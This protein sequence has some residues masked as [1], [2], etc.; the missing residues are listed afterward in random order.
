MPSDIFFNL[1]LLFGLTVTVAVVVRLL[2]QPLLVAYLVSG[3]LAG[4]LFLNLVNSRDAFF[5]SFSQLGVVLLLF[6]VGLSLNTRHI[7][8]IGKTAFKTG[9]GQLVFTVLGALPILFWFG[10]EAQSALYLAI[11]VT[12]SSTIIVMKLLSDQKALETVYG[13]HTAGLLIVQDLFAMGMLIFL[14]N[15][16]SSWQ[17]WGMLLLKLLGLCA[18]LF[19]LSAR[20]LPPI[21]R[22]IAASGEFLFLSSVAWCFGVASIASIAGFSL[23]IGALLAGLSLGSSPYHYD[24]MSKMKPLR[25]FFIVLFFIILGSELQLSDIAAAWGP[26]LALSLFVIIGNPI[27]LY[28]LYRRQKFTR[29]NSFLASTAAAQVSEFGF[30]LLFAG[31]ELGHLSSNELPVFTLTALATIVVSSYVITYNDTIYRRMTPFFRLFGRDR[32]QNADE[33]G[34]T[35]GAWVAGYHRIG[36]KICEELKS[37]GISCAVVDYN[38]EA[39]EKARR[40][41]IPAFFGDVSDM[42]FLESLPIGSAH[43]IVSTI[44]EPEPQAALFRHAKKMSKKIRCIGTAGHTDTLG[45]LYEAGADYVMLPHLLGGR[46]MGELVTTQSLTAR[47]FAALRREQARELRAHHH[48]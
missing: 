26:S 43:L 7:G 24:I 44:P 12:F 2:G 31:R 29:R 19:I 35:Y 36:W 13:R 39:I 3:I 25:D 42:E 22:R 41:G 28:F 6:I 4:P 1:S 32:Y 18:I 17:S 5:H 46:W 34:A 37:H 10:Y 45:D 30:I 47:S 27:I 38:P 48:D 9:A 20:I 33:P 40:R 11:A 14:M 23:E 16:A 8:R 15:Q 21:L